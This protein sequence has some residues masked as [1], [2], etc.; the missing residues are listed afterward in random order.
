MRRIQQDID[1]LFIITGWRVIAFLRF[2]LSFK[3]FRNSE[4]QSP[5]ILKNIYKS[6]ITRHPVV[7]KR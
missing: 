7:I 6:A 4:A 3:D 5:E 2:F 1:H